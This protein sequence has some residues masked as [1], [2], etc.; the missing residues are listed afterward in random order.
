MLEQNID[1]NLSNSIKTRFIHYYRKYP[2]E[3]TTFYGRRVDVHMKSVGPR[4]N[5]HVAPTSYPGRQKDVEIGRPLDVHTTSV[6]KYQ[7]PSEVQIGRPYDV[8]FWRP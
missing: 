7:R 6:E 3:H 5:P 8:R 2:S 4:P 1:K